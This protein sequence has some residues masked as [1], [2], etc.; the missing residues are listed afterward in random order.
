MTEFF[1]NNASSV[2]LTSLAV[3]LAAHFGVDARPFIAAVMLGAS[4]SFATPV[5]YQTNLF[6]YHAGNYKF[7]DFIKI[8]LPMNII[9]WL[10]ASLVIPW[11]WGML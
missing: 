5:G 11:Y 1:S 8:G 3:A 2:I 9:M 6:I 4:A 10:V 7:S